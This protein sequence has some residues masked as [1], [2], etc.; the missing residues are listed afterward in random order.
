VYKNLNILILFIFLISAGVQAQVDS[1]KNQLSKDTVARARLVKQVAVPVKVIHT[2]D[3]LKLKAFKPDPGRVVWM[4]AIIPGYGQILN[5]KYWKLPLVYGGFLGCA[6][7]IAWN[8]SQYNSYKNAYLDIHAYNNSDINYQKA[9]DKNTS[10]VSFYQILPK[11][12][13]PST[14]GGYAEYEKVLKTAQDG[15]RRYRDLSIIA[16]VGYYALTIIDA[17]VDA[18]LYDFD[19][20]P[21]LSLRFQPTLIKNGNGNNTFAMQ[22]NINF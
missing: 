4:A 5:K 15:Y 21:D 22:C 6:Y 18:Q 1:V 20:S 11:G 16:T 14:Y 2:S 12:Y 13:S 10:K 19:I 8:S 3:S 17:Y 7:A 9:I